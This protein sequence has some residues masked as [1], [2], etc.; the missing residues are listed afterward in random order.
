MVSGLHSFF[1][2]FKIYW[3]IFHSV[4]I[5]SDDRMSDNKNYGQMNGV[6]GMPISLVN[7][8]TKLSSSPLAAITVEKTANS[9][10]GKYA[11]KVGYYYAVLIHCSFI[12]TWCELFQVGQAL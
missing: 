5:F 10:V 7:K 4:I 8:A 6:N 2:I 11:Q 12:L 1:A 9:P 3:I